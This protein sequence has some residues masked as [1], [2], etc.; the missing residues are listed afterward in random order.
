MKIRL[1]GKIERLPTG[2]KRARHASPE[3]TTRVLEP[4]NQ[5]RLRRA[6][7]HTTKTPDR[8][9]SGACAKAEVM[10]EKDSKKLQNAHSAG[11]QLQEASKGLETKGPARWGRRTTSNNR[12]EQGSSTWRATGH[13]RKD[14]KSRE[15]MSG[16]EAE[17]RSE[18]M[19]PGKANY[20]GPN[21]KKPWN[22]RRRAY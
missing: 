11:T 10:R 14:R 2:A 16:N 6:L 15:A 13:G 9:N 20:K 3:V 1:Q 18:G 5:N 12:N 7:H 19:R 22:R 21:S 8:F 17:N 4:G